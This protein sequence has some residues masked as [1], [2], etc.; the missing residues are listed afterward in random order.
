[1]TVELRQVEG[2]RAR[3]PGANGFQA[4]RHGGS[5][6]LNALHQRFPARPDLDCWPTTA[7]PADRV[8]ELLVEM[9]DRARVGD[10]RNR[11]WRLFLEWLSGF[12]GSTWQQRWRACGAEELPRQGWLT[13][14]MEWVQH[15]G[16][17]QVTM[18]LNGK[19]SALVRDDKSGAWR[20]EGDDAS[21][22]ERLTDASNGDN[23]GEHWKITTADGTQYYF[24]AGRK[25]G[26]S[27]A[28]AI[29]SAWTTPVYGNNAGEECNKPAFAASWCQQ[30]W[31][32]NLDF[33]VDPRGGVTTHWYDTETNRYKLG[34][35]AATPDGTLTPYIRGGNLRKI[36][37]GS[38]L[39]D[40]DTVKPTAQILFKIDERCLPEKDV[41]DCAPAKLTRANATKWPDVPFD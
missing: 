5:S 26:S 12:P 18:S 38:K 24:G 15:Q 41:F 21:K 7:L 6:E 35:S 39:T 4:G 19:S 1:M 34:V 27:T 2:L 31:R 30:A 32:W 20:L 17:V 11:G 8:Y 36:T 16:R 40:A 23:N 25:P 3:R 10:S 14:P 9:R 22:V 33:V 37:Y 28:P 29:N 13:L